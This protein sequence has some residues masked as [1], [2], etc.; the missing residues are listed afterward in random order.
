MTNKTKKIIQWSLTG[1]V[2]FIF[3]GSAMSKFFG[4]EEALKMAQDIGLTATQFKMIGAVELVSVLLF[5]VPRT[6]ILGTLLLAA[7]MGG[8]IVAHLTHN[9]PILA[10]ILIQAFLWIV[11]LVRFPEMKNRIFG[12]N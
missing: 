8:A 2:G 12:T 3:I 5:I 6:G 4:G 7:Y 11:V 1:I 9:Q 10:P